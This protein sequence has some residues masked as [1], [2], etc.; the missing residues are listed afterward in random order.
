[1][2]NPSFELYNL[3]PDSAYQFNRLQ[4]WFESRQSPDFFHACDS[5]ISINFL[6][7]VSVPNNGFGFQYPH[8]GNGYAGFVSYSYP[9][10]SNYEM[11]R[12]YLSVRLINPLIIGQL[13][14]VSFWVSLT[15]P[16]GPIA[17][18]YAADNLGILCTMDSIAHTYQ[19]LP[20]PIGN[21]AHFASGAIITDTLNWTQIFGSFVA[22]S[23][24]NFITFGNFF[25]DSLTNYLLFDPTGHYHFAYYY[26]DDVCVSTDS[27]TCNTLTSIREENGLQLTISPNPSTGIFTIT[28]PG[29][30]SGEVE[31]FDQLGRKVTS[32]QISTSS[33]TI[34]LSAEPAGMYYLRL[35]DDKGRIHRTEKL[36]KL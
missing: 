35:R 24:Y 11:F 28:H 7:S 8:S 16:R 23:A 10:F 30:T 18:K 9:L 29:L 13:Y 33:T 6:D 15:S 17:F 27:L 4:N 26:I 34:D 1:M 32:M 36:M 5:S 12:E 2:P 25:N 19:T 31:V 14:Y 21:F 20:L 22:D 3:C